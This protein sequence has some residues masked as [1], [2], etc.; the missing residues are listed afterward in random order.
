MN[1]SEILL[2]GPH[3]KIICKAV[4]SSSAGML[5]PSQSPSPP[6]PLAETSA[7]TH[8]SLHDAFLSVHFI[9]PYHVIGVVQGLKPLLLA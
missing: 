9:D 6:S 1:D 7:R 3:Q 8:M 4:T 2:P 5:P